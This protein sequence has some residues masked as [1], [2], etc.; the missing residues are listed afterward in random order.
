MT[1]K[2]LELVNPKLLETVS[3]LNRLG[4]KKVKGDINTTTGI[5]KIY[6]T[7]PKT[8]DFELVGNYPYSNSIDIENLELSD[9]ESVAEFAALIIKELLVDITFSINDNIPEELKSNNIRR[10]ASRN[11]IKVYSKTRDEDWSMD[12]SVERFESVFKSALAIEAAS[13]L[14]KLK[15]RQQ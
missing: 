1:R 13:G 9:P 14:V 2:D 11:L 4:V 7:V 6:I 8:N 12:K 5:Q 3:F 10:L 15:N